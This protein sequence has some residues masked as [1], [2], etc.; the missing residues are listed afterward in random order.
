M[1][2]KSDFYESLKIPLCPLGVLFIF[3]ESKRQTHDLRV[4]KVQLCLILITVKKTELERLFLWKSFI[5]KH[6][7]FFSTLYT[8]IHICVHFSVCCLATIAVPLGLQKTA[9]KIIKAFKKNLS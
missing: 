6:M 7:S 5:H 9:F 1:R 8:T 4:V 2:M 3:L